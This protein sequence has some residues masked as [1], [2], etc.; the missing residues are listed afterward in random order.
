MTRGGP[1]VL[2]M[3]DRTCKNCA[4]WTPLIR[5]GE[6]DGRAEWE[7]QCCCDKFE[8]QNCVKDGLRY[9]D[10]ECYGASFTTGEDFGCIHWK[11]HR[12]EGG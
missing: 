4:F 9:D 3:T 8:Y 5:Q 7:G 12:V 11:A 6:F 1:K 10:C 2:G